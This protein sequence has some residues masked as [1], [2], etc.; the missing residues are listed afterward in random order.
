MSDEKQPVKSENTLFTWDNGQR[1]DFEHFTPKA[2]NLIK[3]NLAYFNDDDINESIWACIADKD[4]EDYDNDVQDDGLTRVALLR[5]MS[6]LGIP[7]GTY[8]PVRFMGK[9]RPISRLEGLNC[10]T[11]WNNTDTEG[12]EGEEDE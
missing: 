3:V 2:D 1:L 11:C 7:W 8:V 9:D 6:V 5:N 12:M 10:K 4:K